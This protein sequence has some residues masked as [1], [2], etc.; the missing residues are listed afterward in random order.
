MI[1][2]DTNRAVPEGET[3]TGGGPEVVDVIGGGLQHF[4]VKLKGTSSSTLYRAVCNEFA[5]EHLQGCFETLPNMPNI[6]S[7]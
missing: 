2:P 1:E 6:F 4:A 5:L 3:E 7:D